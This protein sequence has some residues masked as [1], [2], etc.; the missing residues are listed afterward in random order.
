MVRKGDVSA[1]LY[2]DAQ[3]RIS[4]QKLA[5]AE[6]SKQSRLDSSTYSKSQNHNTNKLVCKKIRTEFMELIEGEESGLISP[7]LAI[8]VISEIFNIDLNPNKDE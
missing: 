7:I 6:L 3:R 8:T 1:L 2:S 4:Q 5:K